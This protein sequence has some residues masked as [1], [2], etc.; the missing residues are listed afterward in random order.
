MSYTVITTKIDPETKRAAQKTAEDLGMPLSVIIKAF[1]KQ[2]VRTQSVSFN[3]DNEEPSEYLRS[4]MKQAKENY[5]RG[6][7]SPTFKNGEDSIDWLKKQG[8]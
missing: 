1:L 7:H 2:L 3:I 6:K 5:K 8:I 4:V